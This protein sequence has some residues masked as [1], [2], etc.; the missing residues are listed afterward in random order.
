MIAEE[1]GHERA[2][3]F[4]EVKARALEAAKEKGTSS[5]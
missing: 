1:D 3:R 5:R 2:E 4:V